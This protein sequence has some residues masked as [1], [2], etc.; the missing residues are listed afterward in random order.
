M[1]FELSN[2]AKQLFKGIYNDFEQ[3]A[4]DKASCGLEEGIKIKS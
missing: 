4:K 1:L 3:L 2:G